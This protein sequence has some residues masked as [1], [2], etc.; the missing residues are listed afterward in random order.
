MS[1]FTALR[2]LLEFL[3]LENLMKAIQP[4]PQKSTHSHWHTCSQILMT[5]SGGSIKSPEST[6]GPL[7][8]RVLSSGPWQLSCSF[9]PTTPLTTSLLPL[10]G[11]TELNCMWSPVYSSLFS[12]VLLPKTPFLPFIAQVTVCH[13]SSLSL[14]TTRFLHT[15]YIYWA[16]TMCQPSTSLA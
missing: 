12:H 9:S 5:V 11:L 15:L 2:R 14:G 4:F 10:Y 16:P 8:P 7:S 6:H 1:A 13:L 3:T